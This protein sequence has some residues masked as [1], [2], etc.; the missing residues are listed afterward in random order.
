M[1]FEYANRK[2]VTYY[3]RRSTTKRGKTRYAFSR[4]PGGDEVEAM[5]EGYEVRESVNGQVSVARARPRQVTE[6]EEQSL[7]ALLAEFKP[8]YRLEVKGTELVIFEPSMFADSLL[9]SLGGI[10]PTPARPGLSDDLVRF[11]LQRS[12]YC[13]VLMLDLVDEDGRR[14]SAHRMLFS[15]KGGWSHPLENGALEP[16][17]RRLLPH[18][19][20]DSYFDLM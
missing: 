8:D 1:A 4:Q 5:P 7:R 13:P 11:V 14:F 10:P 2:G 9:A 19:G 16:L 17:A 3:L 12:R 20:Q 18:L 15:G 6:A